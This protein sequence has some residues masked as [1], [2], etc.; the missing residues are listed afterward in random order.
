MQVD[1]NEY[2][3]K[4]ANLFTSKQAEAQQK[5]ESKGLAFLDDASLEEGAVQTDSGLVYLEVTAAYP[6]PIP[7]PNFNPNPNPNL[8]PDPD[9]D[10]DPDP[11]LAFTRSTNAN[12]VTAGEGDS[13]AAT[14][15]V[16]VHYEGRLLDGTVF[17]SSYKRGAPAARHCVLA[18]P[19]AGQPDRQGPQQTPTPG[20]ASEDRRAGLRP[21]PACSWHSRRELVPLGSPRC[22]G[23]SPMHH[24]GAPLEFP[25][26]GVI[27]GWTEGLQ[28]MKPGGKAKLTIPSDLAYG[29]A[30]TGPIPGKAVL[31]FDVELLAVL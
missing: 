6:D 27:K 26:N 25:L 30:G 3:P 14:D 18:A 5:T 17:D 13:P 7:D 10:P 29:D 1:L 9:P 16:K 19:Q 2:A 28:L 11:T 4:A 12:Q 22:H 21:A 31:V 24:P 23:S 15:K 8:N 20:G